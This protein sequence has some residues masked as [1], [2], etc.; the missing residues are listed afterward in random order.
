[1]DRYSKLLEYIAQD[2]LVEATDLFHTIVS[3]TA[4]KIY[5]SMEAE[6]ELDDDSIGGDAS[7]DLIADISTDEDDQEMR[8]MEEATEEPKT[9][10]VSPFKAQVVPNAAKLVPAPQPNNKQAENTN[11]LT[12]FPKV[13]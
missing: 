4:R 3:G 5:E 12:P 2:K 6:E 1:M 11:N 10:K 7:D 8:N 9:K 13:N